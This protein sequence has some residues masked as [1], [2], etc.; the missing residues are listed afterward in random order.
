MATIVDNA[1]EMDLN[2]PAFQ[3]MLVQAKSTDQK[4]TDVKHTVAES[5][6]APTESEPEDEKPAS[7]EDAQARIKGLEAEL[8]RRKGNAERVSELEEQLAYMKG[9]LD[10]LEKSK[11][12]ESA[13][14][15]LVSAVQ[16]LSDEDLISKQTDWEEELSSLRAKYDRAEEVGDQ[17]NMQALAQKIAYAKQLIKTLRV[18]DKS[19]SERKRSEQENI[20]SSEQAVRTELGDM[21]DT[22]MELHPDF[23]DKDSALW[24]AGNDEFAAYPEVMARLGPVA[25]LVAAAMAIV[26]HPEL[27]GA[28][29]AAAARSEVLNNLDKGFKKAL[30]KGGGS[31]PSVGR[32]MDYSVETGDGLAAFNRMV[33]RIKGG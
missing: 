9:Q 33:D 30:H 16:K 24:K 26:K 14:D 22:V 12:N 13:S 15:K 4:Q 7:P 8:K 29:N 11:Q 31:A 27:T 28:K 25:Q 17:S 1:P 21:V 23:K 19:R 20:Q 6:S 32:T 5:S 10:S 3:Q 2:D 18:E